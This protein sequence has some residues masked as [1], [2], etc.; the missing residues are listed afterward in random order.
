[1]TEENTSRTYNIYCDE[2][3][4]IEHDHK[5]SMFLG[6]ICCAYP[7]RRRFSKRINEL[8]KEHYFYAEIKWSNVSKSKIRFYLDLVD[9]FFDTN[10]V[11]FRTIGIKKTQIHCNDFDSTY[12]DFYY[13][14]YYQLLHYKVDTTSKYNVFLDIK[15]TL[16]AY[17]VHR[18]KDI[19]N[20]KYGVF[21][22]VQNISSKKSVLLQL[23]DFLMG[24]VSYNINDTEH[25]NTAKCQIIERIKR[26]ANIENL[27]KTNYSSKFNIFF[28][29]LK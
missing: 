17:K 15:D 28:I 5:T 2:S 7:Q 27:G 26:R 8:K 13:K 22:I 4:H 24:A 25:Q 20:V 21:N 14:M 11:T 23:A 9:L 12:D 29:N 10:M 6:S 3:C 18:L 1:M 16:S 19:L